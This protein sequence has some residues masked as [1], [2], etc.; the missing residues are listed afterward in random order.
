MADDDGMIDRMRDDFRTVVE[1]RKAN[2][3]W[4]RSDEIEV[5]NLIKEAIAGKERDH[6]LLE[7]WSRWLAVEAEEIRR[8]KARVRELEAKIQSDLEQ[9]RKQAA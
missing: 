4:S 1:D 7:C 6:G 3:L 8:W 5:N 2:G 9:A